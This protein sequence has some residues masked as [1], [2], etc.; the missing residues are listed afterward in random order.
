MTGAFDRGRR[1][2]GLLLAVVLATVPAA[3]AG[4]GVTGS[5]AVQVLLFGDPEELVAYR[6]LIDDFETSSG[7]QVQLI[8]P[9]TEPT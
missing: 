6:E 9:A 5:D 2:L 7:T 1:A 3:C 4:G 8:E